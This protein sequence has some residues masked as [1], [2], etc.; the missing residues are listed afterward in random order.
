MKSGALA[1]EPLRKVLDDGA[2]QLFKGWGTH[3]FGKPECKGLD[4][5]TFWQRHVFH[6]GLQQI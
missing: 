3:P 4:V 1:D 6:D 2:C 5:E